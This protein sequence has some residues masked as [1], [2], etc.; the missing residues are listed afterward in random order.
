M[1]FAPGFTPD[2]RVKNGVGVVAKGCGTH[3]DR[4]VSVPMN[5]QAFP[6]PGV[7]MILSLLSA[8]AVGLASV[9]VVLTV[10]IPFALGTFDRRD[11]H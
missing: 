11:T 3:G 4:P 5:V 1:V 9:V 6:R 10:V 7:A 2:G 8:F